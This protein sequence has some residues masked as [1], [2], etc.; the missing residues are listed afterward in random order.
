MTY[1]PKELNLQALSRDMTRGQCP[2]SGL[3]VQDE[4]NGQP[5]HSA[6][7]G[8]CVP[9]KCPETGSGFMV[10]GPFWSA[11]LHDAAFVQGVLEDIQASFY[12][13]QSQED[14]E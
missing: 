12:Q 4:K 11:P 9:E 14:L 10:G 1:L 7:R 2:T 6:G 5:K 3:R 8:P 13:P